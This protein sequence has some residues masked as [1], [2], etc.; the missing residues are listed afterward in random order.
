MQRFCNFLLA[1]TSNWN[2]SAKRSKLGGG[3]GNQIA[4]ALQLSNTYQDALAAPV[5]ANHAR[6]PIA[7]LQ[8]V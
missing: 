3:A 6:Q 1:T 4:F 7:Q 2:H 8:T 5:R